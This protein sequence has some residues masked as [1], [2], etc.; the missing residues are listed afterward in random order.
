MAVNKIYIPTFISSVDYQP[1]RVLPHIYFYNGL[2][3]CEPWYIEHYSSSAQ[4]SV[5]ASVQN[6]FPYFDYYDGLEPTTGSNSLLFFNE[7]PVYGETPNESLYT[8]YWDTYVSLLYNPKTR[9]IDASAIIPLADY[10]DMELN[11]IVQWR[12]NM[13]HLRA[14]NDYNLKDGTCKLQLLGPIIKDAAQV[15][16]ALNCDFSFS[17]SIENQPA[18]TTTTTLLETTSTT[19][20]AIN[21]PFQITA[22]EGEGQ[23][24]STNACA[25]NVSWPFYTNETSVSNVTIGSKIYSTSGGAN[26]YGESEWYGIGTGIGT[27]SVK[28]IRIDNNGNVIDVYTCV[29]GTT[30]TTTTASPTTQ[31]PTTQAPTTTTTT[32]P[33]T[34]Y[35]YIIHYDESSEL[36]ACGATEPTTVVYSLCNPITLPGIGQCYL[37]NTPNSTDFVA[38]GYYHDTT[39]GLYYYTEGT[40]GLVQEIGTCGTTTLAPTTLLAPCNNISRSESTVF[41]NVCDITPNTLSFSYRGFNPVLPT[42]GDTAYKFEDC[43]GGFAPAGY[44]RIGTTGDYW[45]QVQS[46]GYI[47]Q[48]VECTE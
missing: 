33:P 47:A 20:I 13:Y 27:A 22:V 45:I 12:G 42:V 14:I 2:K 32:T 29:S 3:D 24:S 19:T 23:A 18:T 1:A 36:N 5:T 31:A 15:A 46:N 48:V 43:V 37:Y 4:T 26:W 40:N 7:T 38:G 41:S 8:E 44:Y 30:T 34:Y 28:S 16:P 35:A 25:I 6:R 9:L 21:G 11:D 39:N 10:F 17:S